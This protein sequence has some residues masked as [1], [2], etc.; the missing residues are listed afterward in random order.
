MAPEQ[1][2]GEEVDARSDAARI[3]SGSSSCQLELTRI[4]KF[5]NANRLP[6]RGSSAVRSC[7]LPARP[8]SDGFG[9]GRLRLFVS[10]AHV[11][12][13]AG[14]PGPALLGSVF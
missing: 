8:S 11:C 5:A 13:G 1:I 3:F 12:A 14:L 2:E 4:S 6:A 7:R 10:G 9:I